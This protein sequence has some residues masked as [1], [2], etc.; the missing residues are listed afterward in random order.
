M[1]VRAVAVTLI[2]A[3]TL[4]FEILLVR[5]FAVE[6]FH[7]VAYMAIGVAMLGIGA[8]G[9][10]VAAL[11]GASPRGAHRWFPAAALSTA[12]SLS[13]TPGLVQVVPLDLTQ[14]AWSAQ[15][16]LRLGVVYLLLAVPFA[17]GALTILL[18]I[19]LENT[20][21]GWIYGASFL[22]SGAGALIGVGLLWIAHPTRAL[23]ITAIIAA[24]G[25]VVAASNGTRSTRWLVAAT[26]TLGLASLF[27]LRPPWRLEVSPYKA[28]RQVEAYPD[29]RRIAER[30]SPMGWVVAVRAP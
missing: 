11:G 3:A 9:T 2:A 22:G 28:L 13:V 19:T 4:A 14:L 26:L 30:T 7:H 21:P 6:H 23:A 29:S 20:R 24:L 15:Q 10:L 5:V 12:I 27:A 8:S 25:A 1:T 16:W 17:L 18:A